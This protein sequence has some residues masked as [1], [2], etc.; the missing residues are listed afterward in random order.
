[1]NHCSVLVIRFMN[2][3][4]VDV[5]TTC[6]HHGTVNYWV[7]DMPIYMYAVQLVLLVKA[8]EEIIYFHAPMQVLHII[9]TVIR[10]NL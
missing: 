10:R 1:M 5:G 8:S 4:L 3:F 2:G 7:E 6:I 9:I